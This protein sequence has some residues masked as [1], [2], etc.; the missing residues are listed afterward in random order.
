MY[1]LCDVD[2][3][4]ASCEKVFD[5][6]IRHRPVVVLTNNDGCICAACG[7]AKKMG[8]GKKFVPFF[9]VRE[10]LEKAG[11]VIR[12]SNY[13][14][15]ADMSQRFM[16]TCTAFA[17]YSHIY[18]ID[19]CFLF[20]GG[21]YQPEEGW[22]SH[23]KEIRRTVWKHVR[24]PISVGV[25][26]TPTLA[27]AASHAAKR[28][29]GFNGVAVINNPSTRRHILKNMT[30]TDV[31][32]VG[33]KIGK[34]LNNMGVISAW[35]LAQAPPGLIRKEFNIL[36]ENTVHEL[37][38][39]VKLSWDDVRSP[40][41]EIFSTRSFG[42]R[43]TDKTQLKQAIVTHVEIAARK[44]RKQQ[45]LAKNIFVFA[46]NSP[47][48]T[49]PYFRRSLVHSFPSYT[50]DSSVIATAA[51]QLLD[52]IYRPGIK[53]YKCGVGLLNLCPE[54][55]YQPDLFNPMQDNHE[56]MSCMDIINSKYGRDT[57]HLAG[58]GIQQTFAMRREYLSKQYT[59][60]LCDL[61]AI[62]C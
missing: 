35:D 26:P 42:Q 20:Y 31:W 32:G 16:D 17:P 48:D 7:I 49:A 25:A 38:G 23:A 10:E 30:T 11:A 46:S 34:K 41:K 57:I 19:E 12:S 29:E 8:I 22:F 62:F 14:L 28:I 21:N 60:Q 13:E 37:N 45:S 61:P 56:L 5:P 55:A 58:R 1:A 40:K 15:Y 4:Y 6:S 43:V 39:V 36:L 33:R 54:E 3:M 53:F 50:S 47:H 51:T 18:S 24:L 2:S 52:L 44:L 59:T 27:K 9:Q